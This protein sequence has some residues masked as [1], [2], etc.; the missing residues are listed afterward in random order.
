M[1]NAA[2]LMPL[3]ATSEASAETASITDPIVETT[4]ANVPSGS[5]R[6]IGTA[7]AAY[8]FFGYAMY[9][10]VEE[11]AW[12]IEMRHK[13][14]RKPMARNYSIFV[15]NIPPALLSNQKVEEFFRGCFPHHAIL[16]ARL[17]M[18]ATNLSNVQ[19]KRDATLKK[20]ERALAQYKKNPNGA[21]PTHKQISIRNLHSAI[22]PIGAGPQQVDSIDAYQTELRELNADISRRITELENIANGDISSDNNHVGIGVSST[23]GEADV[24][25]PSLAMI[26]E[27]S[28]VPEDAA[29][30]LTND[31]LSL[32]N[33]NKN[34]ARADDTT[35]EPPPPTKTPTSLLVTTRP[36]NIGRSSSDNNK[37]HSSNSNIIVNN[38][39]VRAVSMGTRAV[40]TGLQDI[41][42][43]V[44]NIDNG[45]IRVVSKGTRVV[46]SGLQDISGKV[47]NIAL[48]A[49]DGVGNVAGNVTSTAAALLALKNQD[50]KV[51]SAGFV[52]FTKL[53]TANAAKQMILNQT[54]FA[55]EAIEAPDPD[56]GTYCY[57]VSPCMHQYKILLFQQPVWFGREKRNSSPMA[58]PNSGTNFF[59]LSFCRQS[60]GPMFHALTRICNWECF[61]RRP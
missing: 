30:L 56:D 34:A 38:G 52:T 51:Q 6:L 14:L 48:D 27:L 54:P 5:L 9:Q 45:V 1:V 37:N 8:V 20:L 55:M 10:I 53:S 3:Y 13:Y 17:P 59:A 25:T 39:V 11:F 29:S 18:I 22:I 61:R 40:S 43:K 60:I 36:M 46:S 26:S 33:N 7:L 16:E 47:S 57:L 23:T 12:F 4:T 19:A 58:T 32:P 21:R 50:G 24:E 42:G 35:A 28:P 31:Q 44:S 15:R 49:V 2:W 41:S